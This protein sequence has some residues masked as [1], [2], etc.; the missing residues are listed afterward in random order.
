[1]VIVDGKLI[2]IFKVE[3]YRNV[4]RLKNIIVM[5][6]KVVKVRNNRFGFFCKMKFGI[7]FVFINYIYLDSCV[8]CKKEIKEEVGKIY[9]YVCCIVIICKLCVKVILKVMVEKEIIENLLFCLYCFIK[10]LIK[11]GLNVEGELLDLLFD[12]FLYYY[13]NEYMKMINN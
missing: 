12:S 8:I 9:M 13:V 3:N 5:L 4:V 6:I 7:L 2:K 11:Y 10:I 1:M